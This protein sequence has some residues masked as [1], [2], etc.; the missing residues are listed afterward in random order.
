MSETVNSGCRGSRRGGIG[1]GRRAS[2]AANA[3]R[4]PRR[5][6]RP[7]PRPGP[8]YIGVLFGLLPLAPD[9]VDG[10]VDRLL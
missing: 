5:P 9:C 8:V 7:R 2:T 10:L 1:A 6:G 4:S 3:A